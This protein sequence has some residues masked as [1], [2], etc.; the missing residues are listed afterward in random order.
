MRSKRDF[1]RDRHDAMIKVHKEIQKERQR[2]SLQELKEQ[3][4]RFEGGEINKR[5]FLLYLNVYLTMQE[6]DLEGEQ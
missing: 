1:Y 2:T 4:E 3:T 6:K 5:E